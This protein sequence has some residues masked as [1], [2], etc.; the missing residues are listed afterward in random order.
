[1]PSGSANGARS[2]ETMTGRAGHA[3]HTHHG[4]HSDHAHHGLSA[5]SA[6]SPQTGRMAGGDAAERGKND[7]QGRSE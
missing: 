5:P 7:E 3:E 1:M 2:G 6:Q 4:H